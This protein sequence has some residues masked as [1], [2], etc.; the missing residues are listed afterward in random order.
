MSWIRWLFQGN[1]LELKAL[2][3]LCVI[4]SLMDTI[5]MG[6]LAN[7][8][9]RVIQGKQLW[10]EIVLMLIATI[11]V[12]LLTR[13]FLRRVAVF[14]EEFAYHFCHQLITKFQQLDFVVYEKM[15]QE[16]ILNILTTE[17]QTLTMSIGF[18]A[19]SILI[20]MM[21]LF[22]MVYLAWLSPV[23]FLVFLG[24]SAL[25]G[26]IYLSSARTVHQQ[27]DKVQVQELALMSSLRHLI[28]GF[29]ELK[30]HHE[31]NREFFDQEIK[32]NVHTLLSTK[33]STSWHYVLNYLFSLLLPL[34][35]AG[36]L[37]F[38]FPLLS[39]DGHENSVQ[40]MLIIL[41]SN[42][43]WMFHTAPK[44]LLAKTAINRLQ[45]IQQEVNQAESQS[46]K[47]TEEGQL[48]DS[49]RFASLECRELQFTYTD[50]QGMPCFHI[51]PISTQIRAG[52]IV[53]IVGGNGSG[54]S[55]LL[56]VL[57]GLYPSHSGE[58]LLNG[59]PFIPE[60]HSRLFSTIFAD[61]HLFD[62]FFGSSHPQDAEVNRWLERMQVKD[63]T[64]FVEGKLTNV[65]LSTGQRKRVALVM[66]LLE[67]CPIY[68]FDEWAADQDPEFREF[69]Y[70]ELLPE[71]RQNGKTVIAVTH[72]DRYFHLADR[73]V[74][75]ELGQ[76]VFDGKGL[77]PSLQ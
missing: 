16:R 12:V 10:N 31:K 58:I 27:M 14:G 28:F 7:S 75:I 4:T 40:V 35:I 37:V 41:F 6:V 9:D 65:K 73:V 57:T 5:Y 63:S 46:Q 34:L 69:F 38:I 8:V 22:L 67:E 44:I 55:T 11:A 56:K 76:V 33:N 64:Q 60:Q 30:L 32:K 13:R 50:S 1:F 19:E 18:L 36:I 77:P 29:K 52:E 71:C 3:Q 54:K 39:S 24:T 15:D 59:E 47:N 42:L 43:P 45:A 2:L 62:Q 48:E 51:G 26:F 70:Q 66:A 23:M 20:G 53:F 68:V 74:K 21:G 25:I 49:F 17:V 61:F 72:D